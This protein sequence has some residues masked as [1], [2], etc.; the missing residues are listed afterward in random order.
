MLINRLGDKF[1]WRVNPKA[2]DC[3]E[4]T[5]FVEQQYFVRNAFPKPWQDFAPRTLAAFVIPKRQKQ[6]HN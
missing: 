1:G 5:T 6:K 4:D 2:L 3:R